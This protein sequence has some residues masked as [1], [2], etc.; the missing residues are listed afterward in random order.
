MTLSSR[1]MLRLIRLETFGRRKLYMVCFTMFTLLQIP[2]ALSPNVGTL[3][4]MRTISGFFGS[5]GIANG[6][7]TISDM[8]VPEELS[9]IHI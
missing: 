8:F 3:I 5:V 9:L 1:N 4:A 6:G 7:G 2:T